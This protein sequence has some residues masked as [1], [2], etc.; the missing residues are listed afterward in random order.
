MTYLIEMD[1][2][3]EASKKILSSIRQLQKEDSSV[4]ITVKKKQKFKPFT[5]KDMVLPGGPKPTKEQLREFLTREDDRPLLTL[6]EVR[7]NVLKRLKKI[8]KK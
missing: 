1:G 8:K 6:E 2:K 5:A 7:A 3:T 4:K